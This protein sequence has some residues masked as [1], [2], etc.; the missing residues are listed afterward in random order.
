MSSNIRQHMIAVFQIIQAVA[1]QEF[2]EIALVI[3][4]SK[5]SVHCHQQA[6]ERRNQNPES[7]WWKAEAGSA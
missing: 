5:I 2:K 7:T 6:I 4:I 1:R 3:G